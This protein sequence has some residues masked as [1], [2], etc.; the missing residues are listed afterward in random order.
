MSKK[1][2]DKITRLTGSRWAV[3]VPFAAYAVMCLMLW[4]P[5]LFGLEP[6]C[7]VSTESEDYPTGTFTYCRYDEQAVREGDLVVLYRQDGAELACVKALY[8]EDM[9]FET[10]S[11]TVLRV[12]YITGTPS[13]FSIEHFGTVFALFFSPAAML[14]A[15]LLAAGLGI[16][17]CFLPNVLAQGKHMEKEVGSEKTGEAETAEAEPKQDEESKGKSA[18]EAGEASQHQEPAAESAEESLARYAEIARIRARMTAK[19]TEA[20]LEAEREIEPLLRND[21]A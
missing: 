12:E 4:T 1:W 10:V 17:V 6:I 16:A 15:G 3:F 11:G 9:T 8:T 18:A 5:V 21:D 2:T 20:V 14:I 19:I 13:E 7:V